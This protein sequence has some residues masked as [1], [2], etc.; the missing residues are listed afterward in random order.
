[1]IALSTGCAS[2]TP[3][4]IRRRDPRDL[5]D[6]KKQAESYKE[7]YAYVHA[8]RRQLDGARP[9]VEDGSEGEPNNLIG[10]AFSGGGIRSAT[11]GLGFL[12][13][14]EATDMLAQF[15]YSSA[16][17]GGGYIASWQQAHLGAHTGLLQDEYDYDVSTSKPPELLS[18]TGEHV[19]HLRTHS[20]FL[21]QGGWAERSR[22]IGDWAWRWPFHIVID[23]LLHLRGTYNFQHVIDIYR[24]RIEG[25]YFRGVPPN[26]RGVRSIAEVRLIDINAHGREAST[27]Y[28]I[29]NANLTNRGDSEVGVEYAKG[30]G[31]KRWNFE[32]TRDFTGSDA[33]GYLPSEGFGHPVRRV[34]RREREKG[35][36]ERPV[37]AYVDLGDRDV[38]SFR[39]SEAAAASGAAFDSLAVAS[40]FDWWGVSELAYLIGGGLLNLNLGL[41][42]PNFARDDHWW[43]L[44]GVLPMLTYQRIPRWTDPGARWLQLT[45]GGHYE[46]LGVLSLLRR[47]TRCVIAV[48]ATADPGRAFEDLRTLHRRVVEELDLDWVTP[49]PDQGDEPL[50]RFVL[51][52]QQ[53]HVQAIVLYVKSSA[54]RTFPHMLEAVPDEDVGP[55]VMRI[56]ADL[57]RG[58]EGLLDALGRAD[59][60]RTTGK[61]AGAVAADLGV[62]VE[63]FLVELRL[64]SQACNRANSAT[65]DDVLQ[66]SRIEELKRARSSARE[67]LDQSAEQLRSATQELKAVQMLPESDTETEKTPEQQKRE[68]ELSNAVTTSQTRVD[69]SRREVESTAR[70]LAVLK[71]SMGIVDAF[72]RNVETPL[73][74][75]LAQLLKR[76]NLDEREKRDWK[77]RF[78]LHLARAHDR[79]ERVERRARDPEQVRA[80]RHDRIE[81]IRAYDA[82]SLTFPHDSTLVQWYTWERFEAYRL[83]GYQMAVTYL[84]TLS[85]TTSDSLEWCDFPTRGASEARSQ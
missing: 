23:D 72:A 16:V 48:D 85:P 28:L 7:E 53:H 74:P 34:S 24:T 81:R 10:I 14:L 71:Q 57:T 65:V 5:L 83:L 12:Q 79:L 54:D 4:D 13:G 18:N 8:R 69:R 11:F 31:G 66:R 43:S 64:D 46:N 61:E 30:D 22:M 77:N 21:N 84:D 63:C 6:E 76:A 29:L 75:R 9:D 51:K 49:L 78:D 40:G 15:D 19:E 1:M 47:G 32:F 59:P 27:P 55:H 58:I 20:G 41:D 80:Q 82:S 26:D 42:V 68:A 70:K 67:A 60:S 36:P 52:N 45:D 2:G 25:T 50:A 39:L 73:A 37:R 56:S 35:K 38:S 44:W 3:F 62:A 17:S 33:T